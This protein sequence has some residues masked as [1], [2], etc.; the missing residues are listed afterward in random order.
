[1]GPT[2][3]FFPFLA[4][5]V[6]TFPRFVM[7]LSKVSIFLFIFLLLAIYKKKQIYTKMYRIVIY[8]KFVE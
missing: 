2:V 6:G 8:H 7:L 3:Y 4:I 5:E 1:M